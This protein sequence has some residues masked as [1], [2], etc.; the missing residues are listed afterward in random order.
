MPEYLDVNYMCL[1]LRCHLLG[2]PH[3]KLDVCNSI[4][5]HVCISCEISLPVVTVANE[6]LTRPKEVQ[7]WNKGCFPLKSE[8]EQ[9][10]CLKWCE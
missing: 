6:L 4:H 1:N 8:L 9:V 3:K 2:T 7:V 5:V 10:G